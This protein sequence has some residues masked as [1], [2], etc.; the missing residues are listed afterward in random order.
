[1]KKGLIG[2]FL[3]FQL[4]GRGARELDHLGPLRGFVDYEFTEVGGR[5]GKHC[6]AQVGKPRSDSRVGKAC[7]DLF[8]ASS[9]ESVGD[10]VLG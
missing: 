9:G 5:T 3:F 4:S 8:V 1:M 6:S 7:I 10:L 2:T